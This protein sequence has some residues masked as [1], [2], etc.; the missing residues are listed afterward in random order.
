MDQAVPPDFSDARCR[1]VSNHL[2]QE[3]GLPQRLTGQQRSVWLRPLFNTDQPNRFKSGPAD[4]KP[5]SKRTSTL[6]H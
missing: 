4:D 6:R 2:Q 1:P 5:E 3:A